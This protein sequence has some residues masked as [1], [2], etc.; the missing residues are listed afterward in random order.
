[1]T[2]GVVSGRRWLPIVAANDIPLD[3]AAQYRDVGL[4]HRRGPLL[5]VLAAFWLQDPLRQRRDYFN[6]IRTLFRYA[7]RTEESQCVVRVL[8][9]PPR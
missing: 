2:T 7:V 4:T 8:L 1:V 3:L 5:V 6:L 9:L